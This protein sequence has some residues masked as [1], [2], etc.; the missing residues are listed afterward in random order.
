VKV[1]FLWKDRHAFAEIAEALEIETDEVMAAHPIEDGFLV[2]YT[3]NTDTPDAI[4]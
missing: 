3:I 1:R 2:L 4:V